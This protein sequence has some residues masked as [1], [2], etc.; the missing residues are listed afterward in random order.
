MN[1]VL[2]YKNKKSVKKLKEKLR[3]KNIPITEIENN[4]INEKEIKNILNDVSI[5]I[6]I[7]MEECIKPMKEKFFYVLY[8]YR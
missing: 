1:I 5:D 7:I 8:T 4:N 3:K 6:I 2:M